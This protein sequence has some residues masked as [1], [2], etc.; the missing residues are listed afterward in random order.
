MIVRQKAI[1]SIED[2]FCYLSF[3]L[4]YSFFWYCVIVTFIYCIIRPPMPKLLYCIK[5][6]SL[7]CRAI[8]LFASHW[9]IEA[10]SYCGEASKGIK[11][12]SWSSLSHWVIKLLSKYSVLVSNLI[13]SKYLVDD[14]CVY[15]LLVNFSYRQV[16]HLLKCRRGALFL[17]YLIN[18]LTRSLSLLLALS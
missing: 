2:T 12:S 3:Y 8:G 18:D 6:V 15:P 16:N 17:Y 11:I 5:N 10:L 4:H 1:K 14:R 7:Y 9:L 13:S